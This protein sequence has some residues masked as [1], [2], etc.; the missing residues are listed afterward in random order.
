MH[1]YSIIFE[2]N[3]NMRKECRAFFF[4]LL[5]PLHVQPTELMESTQRW[6]PQELL[7]L[8]AG[9]SRSLSPTMS[10]RPRRTGST[11]DSFAESTKR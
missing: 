8:H 3:C 4:F 6:I 7:T 9:M 2:Y 10:Q 5:S 11:F 1:K